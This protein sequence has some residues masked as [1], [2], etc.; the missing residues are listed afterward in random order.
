MPQKPQAALEDFNIPVDLLY[1]YPAQLPP[2]AMRAI[3]QTRVSP[4]ATP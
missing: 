3:A 4:Q 1:Y 2:S